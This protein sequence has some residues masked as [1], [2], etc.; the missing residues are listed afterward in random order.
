MGV[1]GKAASDKVTTP[2][3]LDMV[4]RGHKVSNV[5]AGQYHTLVVTKKG[6]IFGFGDNEQN[7]LGIVNAINTS[8]MPVKT[9]AEVFTSITGVV[10][11]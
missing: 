3:S 11:D 9:P 10:Q 1:Q 2:Q 5:A 4:L 8:P 7:Q 6:A